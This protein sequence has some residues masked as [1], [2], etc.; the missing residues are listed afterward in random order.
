M[1]SLPRLAAATA[2]ALLTL[3]G[4]GLAA[5]DAIAVPAPTLVGSAPTSVHGPGTVTFSYTITLPADV[6]STVFSTHQAAALPASTTGVTLDGNPVP[7][8][9][10]TQPSSVDIAVQ[11]GAGATDGLTAG[12]HT[13]TFSAAVAASGSAATSSTARLSWTDGGLPGSVTSAPVLV[14]VNQPDLAVTLTPDSGED[15][16]GFLGTGQTL[17]LLVD[18]A[19]VGYG[20]PL[21]T[22]TITLPAGMTLG[23][24]GVS[25]DSDGSTL[26]CTSGIGN[27]GVCDLGQLVRGASDPTLHIELASAGNEPV[28]STVPVTVAAAPN[29]GEGVDS[30][31]AND[32]ATVQVLYTGSARLSYTL[33][34]ASS[35]VAIGHTTTVKLTVHNSGPQPA[36]GTLAFAI[37]V[38]DRFTVTKFTGAMQ[39][40]PGTMTPGITTLSRQA[41]LLAPPKAGQGGGVTAA[42]TASGGTGLLWFIGDIPVGG[43]VSAMLTVKA[44]ALGKAQVG[45]LAVSGAGDPNCTNDKC[46]P[47]TITLSAVAAAAALPAAAATPGAAPVAPALANTGASTRP[48][49]IGATLLVLGLALTFG[50][51]RRFALRR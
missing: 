9:Q 40:L 30:N 2:A 21:S 4:L 28:G 27:T 49:A 6:S 44:T 34:P 11:T 35:K 29:P 32:S 14:Q 33:T 45:L 39:P 31:P 13:L 51:R 50:A 38:G 7:A 36:P 19:N 26:N 3:T 16:V 5:T 24:D 15:Q 37:V 47:A 22:L 12:T 17:D 46:E 18:V 20:T 1:R 48:A 23:P 42:P 8:A 41:H 25:R 10:I 43:S